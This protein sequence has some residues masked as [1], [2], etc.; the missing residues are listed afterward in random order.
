MYVV[1][2]RSSRKGFTNHFEYL[3]PGKVLRIRKNFTNLV[4][5]WKCHIYHGLK[6]LFWS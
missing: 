4:P 6:T 1:G 5:G 2:N 3:V